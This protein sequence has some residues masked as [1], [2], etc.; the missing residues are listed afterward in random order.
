MPRHMLAEVSQSRGR[1]H[2]LLSQSAEAIARPHIAAAVEALERR[3]MLSTTV[4]VGPEFRV[5]TYTT[6]VQDSTGVAADADGNFVIVWSGEGLGDDSGIFAQ[7]Y[8][9][10]GVSQGSEF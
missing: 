7:R 1:R 6:G 2:G 9:D 4:P 3:V 8:D 10:A 5:N